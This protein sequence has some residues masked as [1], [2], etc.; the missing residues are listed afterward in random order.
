MIPG[1][2]WGLFD[3]AKYFE[4]AAHRKWKCLMKY[5]LI[6]A[7]TLICTVTPISSQAN[8]AGVS[9]QRYCTQ[10][11]AF[12]LRFHKNNI[13]GIFAALPESATAGGGTADRP[14]AVAGALSNQTVEGVWTQQDKRGSIRMGFSQDWSSFVA[15]YAYE[16]DPENWI[17]GWMGYLPPAGD[18][19]SFIIDG[20][21]FDCE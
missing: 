20:E 17:S 8:T 2:L 19:S 10:S 6:A 12:L 9:E 14:G 4:A 7:A 13:A 11:G 18:P 15:A 16:D 21:R 1:Q 5:A 3:W